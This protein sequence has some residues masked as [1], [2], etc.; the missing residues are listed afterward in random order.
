MYSCTGSV[1]VAKP[2]TTSPSRAIQR[3]PA[4]SSPRVRSWWNISAG[5]PGDGHVLER[6]VVDAGEVRGDIG[7][8][9]VGGEALEAQTNCHVCQITGGLPELTWVA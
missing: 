2:T 6:G 4:G 7:I 1:R 3:A 9:L 8:E 5:G